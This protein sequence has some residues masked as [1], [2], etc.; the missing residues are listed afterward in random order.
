MATGKVLI[1]LTRINEAFVDESSR[2]FK[3][4]RVK[5]TYILDDPF[6]APP[7]LAELIPQ[8]SPE[9]KPPDEVNII[10]L[11]S[12][13]LAPDIDD[14]RLEDDWVPLDETMDPEQLEESMREKEAHSHAVVL[15]MEKRGD[16]IRA[17]SNASISKLSR[18]SFQPNDG[19]GDERRPSIDG[20]R[21]GG[22][23][24]E[25]KKLLQL[26]EP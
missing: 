9:G 24:E 7:Q 16:R 19:G 11:N 10:L 4:I 14:V 17:P 26:T 15:E 18:P 22:K 8:A 2:P 13:S 5:H 21:G 3:N 12:S 6:D 23:L 25:S 20:D 1:L